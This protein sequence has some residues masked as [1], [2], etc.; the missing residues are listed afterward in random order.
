MVKHVQ[1]NE[2]QAS[3]KPTFTPNHW[4]KKHGYFKNGVFHCPHF[5]VFYKG[6][7]I[8][9]HGVQHSYHYLE[10]FQVF[11]HMEAILGEEVELKAVMWQPMAEFNVV[12]DA[13]LDE[14]EY[15]ALTS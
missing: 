7:P 2:H 9:I 14:E 10:A 12:M 6:K 11:M 8:L 4:E 3:N 13:S 1:T 5:S 15:K